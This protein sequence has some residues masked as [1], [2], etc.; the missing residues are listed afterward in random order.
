M[1]PNP[2]QA[3]ALLVNM[4]KRL[5]A[6]RSRLQQLQSAALDEQQADS[7]AKEISELGMDID[8]F[9]PFLINDQQEDCALIGWKISA[10]KA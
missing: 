8:I 5:V 9:E 7:V 4:A 10:R 6:D 1:K 2:S 3:Q